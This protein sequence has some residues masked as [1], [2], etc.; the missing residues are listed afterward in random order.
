[1]VGTASVPT[2][3]PWQSQFVAD[4]H[5]QQLSQWEC[6]KPMRP[7]IRAQAELGQG[8][9]GWLIDGHILLTAAHTAL[10]KRD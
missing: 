10:M 5:L 1:M 9:S 8:D 3:A 2:E 4:F 7:H 6:L